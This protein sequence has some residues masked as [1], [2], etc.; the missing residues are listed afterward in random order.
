MTTK[1]VKKSRSLSGG[2]GTKDDVKKTDTTTKPVIFDSKE[3]RAKVQEATA[4][5]EVKPIVEKVEKQILDNKHLIT[6]D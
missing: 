4:K 2:I 5:E 3:R 1:T 6:N